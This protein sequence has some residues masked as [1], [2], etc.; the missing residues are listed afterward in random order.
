MNT[1]AFTFFPELNLNAKHRMN[2]FCNLNNSEGQLRLESKR[3]K[4]LNSNIEKNKFIFI[5]V[6][7]VLRMTI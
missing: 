5:D 3:R 7:Y 2:H 4:L 6:R 1:D